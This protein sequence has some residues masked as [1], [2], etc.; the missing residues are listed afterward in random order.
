MVG[1]AINKK[2]LHKVVKKAHKVI[3]RKTK[4]KWSISEILKTKPPKPVVK[5][6]RRKQERINLTKGWRARADDFTEQQRQAY[7][8]NDRKE[9]NR[10]MSKRNFG[11]QEG[12]K[13]D[14]DSDR[15]Y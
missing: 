7:K 5:S 9:Y 15:L 6:V 11:L 4:G 14:S 8:N 10:V 3:A 12:F 1:M 2:K 13:K